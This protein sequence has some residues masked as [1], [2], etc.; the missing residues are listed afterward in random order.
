MPIARRKWP[1]R[2]PR[3]ARRGPAFAT[4]VGWPSI[5]TRTTLSRTS[6][7]G[8][9]MTEH[10]TI[11]FICPHGAAK[12]VLAAAYF[13]RMAQRHGLDF[14]AAFAGVEPDDALSPRV[15]AALRAEG[16]HV[17]GPQPRRVRP[18]DL[19]GAHRVISLGADLSW[20]PGRLAIVEHWD[21]V[22]PASQN[23]E[24]TRAAIQGR[25]E[26]LVDDLMGMKSRGDDRGRK[27]G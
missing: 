15:V 4:P 25:L 14:R 1:S 5:W 19:A 26:T 10:R 9:R 7:G 22:P 6:E 8:L 12:S 11:L 18:E 24:A 21:D 23:L 2:H 20:L 16:I 13:D 27:A 17:S 3:M